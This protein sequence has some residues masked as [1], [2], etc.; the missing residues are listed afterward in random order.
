MMEQKEFSLCVNCCLLGDELSQQTLWKEV[1][2]PGDESH[3]CSVFFIEMI[4]EGLSQCGAW[5]HL[6]VAVQQSKL[7]F[8]FLGQG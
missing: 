6:F 3:S 2:K 7:D 1:G 5:D 8:A 4:K